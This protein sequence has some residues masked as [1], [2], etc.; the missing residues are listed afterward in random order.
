MNDCKYCNVQLFADCEC[1]TSSNIHSD[2][3]LSL[4]LSKYATHT[5]FVSHVDKLISKDLSLL[6]INVRSLYKNYNLKVRKL[7]YKHIN[8]Q[9]TVAFKN[10]FELITCSSVQNKTNQNSTIRFTT[11]MFKLRCYNDKI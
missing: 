8:S 3:D 6:H 5:D 1:L 7:M 10:Y 4:P 11:S 9:V 2:S